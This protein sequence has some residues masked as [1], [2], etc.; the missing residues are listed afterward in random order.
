MESGTPA[1]DEIAIGFGVIGVIS[2]M[3]FHARSYG[4]DPESGALMPYTSLL[5]CENTGSIPRYVHPSCG[6]RG[7]RDL[8]TRR[9]TLRAR[10]LERHDHNY[11]RRNIARTANRKNPRRA[12]TDNPE[13]RGR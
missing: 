13:T 10:E 11:A 4:D 7:S 2:F 1:G 8:M 3:T 12:A 9:S 6:Y 5:Q